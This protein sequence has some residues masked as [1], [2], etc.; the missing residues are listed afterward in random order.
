MS[1]LIV[2][3]ITF[4]GIFVQTVSGFGLGLVAMPL[5]SSTLGLD[6]ARPL[7]VLI[8]VC[9][10]LIMTVRLRKALNLGTVGALAVF[11]LIGIPI[12]GW[13]ADSGIFTEDTMLIGLGV[14][15]IAYALYS[16]IAPALPHLKHD[17]LSGVVGLLSG[18]LTGAYNVGGPPVVIYA[19]ARRWS[20]E[21]VR[22]NLQGFFLLKGVVL[23]VWHI[24]YGNMTAPVLT[25][26]VWG[27]PAIA[28]G[29]VAGFWLHPHI[30]AGRFRQIVLVLLLAL[31][32][33]MI[34]NVVW[35]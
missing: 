34:L 16:L 14:I 28:A 11:G 30:N 15:V 32:A 33:N 18:M 8:A 5:L 7:M 21:A 31:G 29:M 2:V 13:L 3:V 6:I 26:F 24:A 20:P 23:L 12:G 19:D 27:I 9:S 25:G 22:V 17:R 1:I 4:L 35:G 10:Q